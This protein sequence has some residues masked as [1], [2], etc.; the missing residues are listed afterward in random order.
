M[1]VSP[2]LYLSSG[3]DIKRM[4]SSARRSHLAMAMNL[5]TEVRMIKGVGPQ[6]AELLAQRGI[7]TLED[8][9]GY[10]PFRYEDRIHFS[11][12]KDIQPNG[13]YTIRARVMSGQAIRGMRGGR[14]AI[15]HLLV[16]DEAGGSLPVKF[17]HGGFLQGR[18][19]PGQLP[20]LYGQAEIYNLH[21]PRLAIIDPQ[22]EVLHTE[23]TDSTQS[24]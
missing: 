13:V 20:I 22:I 11:K 18:L 19:K 12:V 16:Q 24:R 9:L 8:L 3:N 6:R 10:L 14:D 4:P 21:P 15:Y 2:A 1:Q 5:T 23:G 17:F 7:H